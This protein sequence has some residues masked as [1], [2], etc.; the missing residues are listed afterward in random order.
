MI[1]GKVQKSFCQ[2]ITAA[3]IWFFEKPKTK[4]VF[5]YMN[6]ALEQL[7]DVFIKLEL[8]VADVYKIFYNTFPEDSELWLRLVL[9]EE[10]HAD[11]IQSMKGTFLLPRQF[12][13]ELLAPSME[14][15][16][17]TNNR[18]ISMLKK[19]SKKP[20]LRESAFKIAL[21]IERSAGEFNFQLA[22]EKSPDSGVMKIFQELNKDCRNHTKKIITYM[23]NKGIELE[24]NW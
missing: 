20:P 15:L 6:Q 24:V 9:E 8:N 11:L 1:F 13:S 2:S 14:M 10:K 4:P 21:D 19:Y 16:G 5:V 12:P 7:I 18:L 17:K 23:R 3:K 22:A